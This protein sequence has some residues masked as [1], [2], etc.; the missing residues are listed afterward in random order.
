M[1]KLESRQGVDYSSV[2][3]QLHLSCCL[4]PPLGSWLAADCSLWFNGDGRVS[5]KYCVPLSGLPVSIME[6]RH[7]SVHISARWLAYWQQ[8]GL[9]RVQMPLTDFWTILSSRCFFF[10]VCV[11]WSLYVQSDMSSKQNV[12]KTQRQ[13]QIFILT[14]PAASWPEEEGLLAHPLLLLCLN[15]SSKRGHSRGS[16]TGLRFQWR[17]RSDPVS[18]ETPFLFPATYTAYDVNVTQRNYWKD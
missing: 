10:F 14:L 8:L 11:S 9:N 6:L 16:N 4:S 18:R 3:T 15:L 17:G 12:P 1:R 13:K 2:C 7:L 5:G